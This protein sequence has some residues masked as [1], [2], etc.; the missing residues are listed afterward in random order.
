MTR[1]GLCIALYPIPPPGASRSRRKLVWRPDLR[2]SPCANSPYAPHS[3]VEKPMAWKRN[4]G[5]SPGDGWH[6]VFTKTIRLRNGRVLYAEHY[7]L[8]C[9]AFWAKSK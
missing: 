8:K 1:S 4:P 5:P 6:L 9:F 7:G 3:H 2:L